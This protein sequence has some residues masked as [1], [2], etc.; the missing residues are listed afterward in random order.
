M[1]T[2]GDLNSGTYIGRYNVYIVI[3]SEGGY[4][5]WDMS[6]QYVI[7][8]SSISGELA[9]V[10]GDSGSWDGDVVDGITH[11]AFS[12][13]AGTGSVGWLGRFN[14]LILSK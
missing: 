4:V 7:Y 9:S 13:A 11:W 5:S 10:F 3:L 12:G 8:L 1:L 2:I 6:I 14:V